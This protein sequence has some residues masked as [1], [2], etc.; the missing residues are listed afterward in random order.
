MGLCRGF[1]DKDGIIRLEELVES[2][3]QKLIDA[4][5]SSDLGEIQTLSKA[6]AVDN[7]SIEE[8]FMK[9]EEDIEV[10][11]SYMEEYDKKLEE[12]G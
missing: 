9:M 7:S 1:G 5:N 12:I 6:I 10:L 11:D 8:L 2:N 3:N 4:S